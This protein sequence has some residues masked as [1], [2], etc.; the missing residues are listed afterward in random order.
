MTGGV[1]R[2]QLVPAGAER[3][4][5]DGRDRSGSRVAAGAYYIRVS[6][7]KVALT[8]VILVR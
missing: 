8:R 3:T 1:V 6:G 5:W 2:E 4:K 7:G